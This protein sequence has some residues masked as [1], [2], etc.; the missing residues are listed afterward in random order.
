MRNQRWRQGKDS[1]RPAGEPIAP[2]QYGVE[3]IQEKVARAFVV[4]QHYSRSYPAARCRVGL[5]RRHAF[6]TSHLVGVAVFSVC[7]QPAAIRKHL[8]VEPNHGVELGRFVLLDDVPGNGETWFLARAFRLLRQAKP[9]V[10]AV[11]SYADPMARRTAAGHL[12][13]PGHFGTIYQAFNA[14]HVGRT[15][16]ETLT[17]DRAGRV[18]SRRS[19]SKLR[20]GET[21]AH[22]AYNRLLEAGAPR[23][24]PNEDG[25]AYVE[26]ALREGPFR[27]VRHPGNL[28]Y[29]WALD[30]KTRRCLAAPQ[31]YPKEHHL[32]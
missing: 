11:L 13:K 32:D 17:L 12:I 26:R 30:K 15:R 25:R 9:D 5:Y 31:P 1:Y 2:S 19:L 20:N 18:L 3:I 6:E 8:G 29:A 24:S 27:R 10:R 4:A 22:Y 28:A 7:M 16:G 23:R 14:R 21:G